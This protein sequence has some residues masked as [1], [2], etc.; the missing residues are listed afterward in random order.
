MFNQ[1]WSIW[2]LRERKFRRQ[3][4][5]I[6]LGNVT[7][8]VYSL[9]QRIHCASKSSCPSSA[10]VHTTSRDHFYS[11]WR[12]QIDPFSALLALCAGNSPARSFDVFF[13]LNKR[14]SKQSRHRWFETPSHLLW[15]HFNV[16]RDKVAWIS[17]DI[18][19]FMWEINPAC[20]NDDVIEW[21]HFPRY[22][23]FVREIHRSPVNSL[24]KA[25]WRGALIFL[26]SALWI[27]GWVNNLEADD[28]R[29]HRPH[30]DVIVMLTPT[31]V[32]VRTWMCNYIQSIFLLRGCNYICML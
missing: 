2:K 8:S 15:R 25:Q 18:Y 10:H 12:H 9:N 21:K 23:S 28:L 16:F 20:P 30:Y 5:R 29:R 31:T 27:N 26:W 3:I 24:H 6:L 14:S 4:A 19:C 1:R 32:D 7:T 11:W 17:N 13:D 22:W